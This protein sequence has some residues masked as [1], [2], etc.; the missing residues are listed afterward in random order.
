[1]KNMS[2][3]IPLLWKLNPDSSDPYYHLDNKARLLESFDRPWGVAVNERNEIGVTDCGNHRIQ[4]FRSSDGTY[5]RSFGRKGDK[6][7]ELRFP[8]GIAFNVK[9][10]NLFV[11]DTE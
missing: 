4:V 10:E 5:L 8:R 3:A 7:G 9:N 6:N 2:V 11:T 1:M